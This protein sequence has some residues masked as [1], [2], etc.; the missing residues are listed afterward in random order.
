MSVQAF[1]SHPM[2]SIVALGTLCFIVLALLPTSGIA[3]MTVEEE[4][5][6][7]DRLAREIQQKVDIVNDPLIKEYV[8]EIGRRLVEEAQDHRFRYHFYVV[9]EQE[10]NA[11]AIPGG[12]I[13]ITSGLIRFVDT[14]DEFAGVVGHE[15]AHSVLRHIDKAMERARRLSLV[16]LAAIIA[17]AFLSKDAKSTAVLTSGAMAMAQSLMLKYTRENEVEADQK[18][19]KYLTDAG[20]DS[21]DMVIFLK[22]IYRWQRSVALDIPTYLS[23]HPGIDDRIAYLSDT[24]TATP[25]SLTTHPR[26]AGDLEKIQIRLFLREKGGAEGINQFSSLLREKPG[27]V[28]ILYGLGCSYVMVG[29]THEALSYLSEA[30]KASPKDVYIVRELGIAYFQAKEVDKALDVLQDALHTFSHDTT[31]L[32]YLAQGNEEKGRWNESVSFY[33]RVLE[34]DPGRVEIYYNLGVV[35]DKK[36]SLDLSHETFGLYFKEKGQRE[37]ALFHFKKAL[38]HTRDW[39]KKRHLEE[40]IKECEG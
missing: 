23:T 12:H 16:T 17:G 19:I 39:K 18:G 9:R 11:F 33:Q 7:G 30:L 20:Y 4:R 40:L 34:L 1:S 27:D 22:K 37:T 5:E 38:E 2:R 24:F 25:K 8:D 6:L 31:I 28:N 21:Q 14:E 36:G 26:E 10:P 32:Y 3:S 29:R 13:F 15:I 35:Y